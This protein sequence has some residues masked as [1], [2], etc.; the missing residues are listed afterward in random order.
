MGTIFLVRTKIAR[1][2]R[3]S[4]AS[5]RH[6]QV[7]SIENRGYMLY[8]VGERT[9]RARHSQVCSIENR[10]CYMLYVVICLV[11]ANFVPIIRKE[12][13]A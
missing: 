12:G 13:G 3:A 11:R 5:E 1:N 9:K 4:E 10:V 6:S 7:C 8:V 2:W